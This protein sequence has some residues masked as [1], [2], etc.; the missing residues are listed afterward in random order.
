[1]AIFLPYVWPIR[2]PFV[3]FVFRLANS[4]SACIISVEWGF[5][6]WGN[7]VKNAANKTHDWAKGRCAGCM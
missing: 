3:L 7:P 5:V 1:V 6:A 4:E 2:S